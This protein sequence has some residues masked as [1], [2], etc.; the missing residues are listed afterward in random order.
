MSLFDTKFNYEY[1]VVMD[2]IY[3][4]NR[5]MKNQLVDITSGNSYITGN[6]VFE[7]FGT[8]ILDWKKKKIYFPV[9]D[10]KEDKDFK[11]LGLS[12]VY[13]EDVLQV[14]M[15]WENSVEGIDEVD[16][17][18]M[19][20]SINNIPAKDMPREK[21]CD[22]VDIFTDKDTDRPVPVTIRKK[23]GTERQLVLQRTDL[24]NK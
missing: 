21:W 17:G 9:A 15:V 16:P 3:M 8:M 12:P 13:I 22:I 4:G 2:S 11:T 7:K 6:K 5:L 19:I 18:D 20:V 10:V 24:F 23:D 1:V 14:G